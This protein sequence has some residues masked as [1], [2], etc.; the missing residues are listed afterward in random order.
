MKQIAIG[1]AVILNLNVIY[2]MELAQPNAQA[3]KAAALTKLQA[4]EGA[5]QQLPR[6]ELLAIQHT[7]GLAPITSIPANHPSKSHADSLAQ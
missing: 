5:P 4:N 1:L 6:A 2:G 7:S 3:L